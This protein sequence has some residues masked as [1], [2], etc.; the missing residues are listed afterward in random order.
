[1]MPMISVTRFAVRH[2]F[3]GMTMGMPPPTLASKWKSTPCFSIASNMSLPNCA[4]TSLFAVTTFLPFSI[5]TNMYSRAGWMPPRSS[6]TM[7]ISSSFRI[8]STFSVRCSPSIYG[9]SFFASRTSTDFSVSFTPAFAVISRSFSRSTRTTPV[10]TVPK[11]S[12]P[13]L[14]SFISSPFIMPVRGLRDASRRPPCAAC[15]EALQDPPR[16]SP[17]QWKPSHSPH[18]AGG[19]P[20]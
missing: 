20:D 8:S 7:S 2:C 11:P 18:P 14:I 5:A 16:G 6:M 1:M 12:M 9:R 13:I 15:R 3:S 19:C 10:P 4:T 17:S